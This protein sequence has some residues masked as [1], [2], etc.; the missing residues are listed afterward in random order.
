MLRPYKFASFA[1]FAA[2]FFF[3][4]GFAVLRQCTAESSISRD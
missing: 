4:C 1:F 2:N 3:G